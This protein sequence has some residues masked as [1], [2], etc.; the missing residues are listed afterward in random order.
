MVGALYPRLDPSRIRSV[1]FSR[2]AW[3]RGLDPDEVYAF[4]AR[5]ADEVELL[6]RDI[7]VARD[8]ADRVKNALRNWQTRNARAVDNR[9][10][11]GRR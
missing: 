3:R 5:M 10:R 8:D 1:R 2:R 7:R 6:R 4:L 9:W 11:G